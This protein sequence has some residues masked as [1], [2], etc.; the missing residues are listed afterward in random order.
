MKIDTLRG[1]I[2]CAVLALL[3]AACDSG[4]SATISKKDAAG[5]EVGK[6]GDGPVGGSGDASKT[7]TGGGEAGKSGDV[8]VGNPGDT[9]GSITDGTFFTGDAKGGSD[10]VP[11]SAT[12]VGA[13]IPPA[14]PDTGLV[15]G[16]SGAVCQ[17]A[18][19]C[20]GLDCV[21]G[22]CGVAACLSDGKVCASSGQ[23]CSTLCGAGGTCTALNSTCKTAG[24]ACT[25]NSECCNGTCN[26]NHQCA[27][28]GQVSYCVQASDLCRNNN[29]CCTGVCSIALG[30]S[31]GT[32]ANIATSCQVDGTVCSGCGTCCSH[33]CGPYGAGGPSI[34][35]PA[36][37]CH[38]QGDLCRKDSDCCGGDVASGLPGA[39]LIKCEPDPVFGSTI[40][41]CG[42]PKASNCPNGES[43][44]KNSCN[45][46]GNVCHYKQTL[47][48][49]G[50]LTNVRNDCCDCISSKDCCQTD[51]MGIPRC[52][53]LAACVP[54]GG[55]C[56]FSG[57][58]CNHEPCLPDPVT[59]RLTCGSSCSPAGG[60]CTTNADC[61]TGVLCQPTPGSSSGICQ[62]PTPPPTLDA[63]VAPDAGIESDAGVATDGPLICAYWGQ[64]CSVS[65]ACCGSVPC[66]NGNELPCTVG[67]LDCVCFTLE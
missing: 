16:G 39:G 64:S 34:C 19:D 4:S 18:A 8:P 60:V 51:A 53:S 17:S 63:G 14:Y 11:F 33:F 42:G 15:C 32:C 20:C 56:S 44:C 67:D 28:P 23:C 36:S 41:T 48:C 57:E 29:E 12:D 22:K 45:P 6:G 43:T 24:N 30:A 21:S 52:N 9:S 31:A 61:C 40:G 46:E 2:G 3:I 62:I 25:G 26:T 5:G 65:V 35:Q 54:T 47:V 55:N 7:D 37:G 49:S 13:D 10:D 27:S 66:L 59:G 58:C 38:V 50:N 1:G